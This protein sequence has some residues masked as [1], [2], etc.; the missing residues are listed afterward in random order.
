M[1]I[2]KIVPGRFNEYKL[3]PNK[4]FPSLYKTKYTTLPDDIR[5]CKPEDFKPLRT[6]FFSPEGKLVNTITYAAKKVLNK[7]KLPKSGA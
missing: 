6:D 3:F 2:A 1:K 4:S 5:C 7:Y